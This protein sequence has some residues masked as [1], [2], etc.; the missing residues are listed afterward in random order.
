MAK[1]AGSYFV[2]FEIPETEYTFTGN[3]RNAEF[4]PT[5]GD[6]SADMRALNSYGSNTAVKFITE[7]S[8]TIKRARIVGAGAP[9]LQAGNALPFMACRLSMFAGV[10]HGEG[11]PVDVLDS[12]HLS[13]TN[14]GEWQDVN[15]T[16]SP[17]ANAAALESLPQI[18]DL[19]INGGADSL[20]WCDDFNLQD[21]FV[22]QTVKPV[23][24]LEIDTAGMY[25][26]DT[27]NVF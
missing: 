3:A 8:V 10:G 7:N 25:D 19:F 21:D 5:A 14:W 11:E 1:I 2:H 15:K 4:H 18:C 22:G 16:F 13:L 12:F 17:Y 23:L 6:K 27:R 9:G 26:T 20:F 24:E